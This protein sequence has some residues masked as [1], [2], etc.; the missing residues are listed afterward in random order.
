MNKLNNHGEATQPCFTLLDVEPVRVAAIIPNSGSKA[1][2]NTE[3][4]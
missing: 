2:V 4:R 3:N 1:A